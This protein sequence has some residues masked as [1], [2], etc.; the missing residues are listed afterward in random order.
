[1]LTIKRL[2][3]LQEVDLGLDEPTPEQLSRELVLQGSKLTGRGHHDVRQDRVGVAVPD[4]TTERMSLV[5]ESKKAE[6]CEG[7]D[8]RGDL[9]DDVRCLDFFLLVPDITLDGSVCRSRTYASLTQ[10]ADDLGSTTQEAGVLS[11][12]L[13]EDDTRSFGIHSELAVEAVAE[14]LAERAEPFVVVRALLIAEA[15]Q[16]PHHRREE[17]LSPE[18]HGALDIHESPAQLQKHG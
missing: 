4:T 15:P 8:V 13:R 11:L 3:L 2:V 1:M 6:P 18:P 17:R 7:R 16:L 9:R 10:V 14:E 12:Q 5:H